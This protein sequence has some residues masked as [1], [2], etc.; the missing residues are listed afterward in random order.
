VAITA[1]NHNYAV[2]EE[3]LADVARG[4]EVTHRNLFDGVVEG[5]RSRDV[6]IVSVQ[7]HPEAAPGPLEERGYMAAEIASASVTICATSDPSSR[8]LYRNDI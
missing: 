3:S 2:D 7:Y 6:R 1:Q 5:M 8:L 4:V